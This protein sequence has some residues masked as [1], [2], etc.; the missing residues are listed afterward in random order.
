MTYSCG[1]LVFL[2]FNIVTRAGLGH[3]NDDM[4]KFDRQTQW[5]WPAIS[6]VAFA[7]KNH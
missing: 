5:A 1:R 7:T 6:R 4:E 2:G 3:H